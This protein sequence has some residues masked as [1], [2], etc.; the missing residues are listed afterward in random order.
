[1]R[2]AGVEGHLKTHTQGEYSSAHKPQ[3]DSDG[4]ADSGAR[5]LVVGSVIINAVPAHASTTHNAIF[6]LTKIRSA[7][8]RRAVQVSLQQILGA[9]RG[10]A[11]S[12]SRAWL[13]VCLDAWRRT[14][15]V[16]LDPIDGKPII[17]QP[18]I[19]I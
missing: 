2:D 17:V 6:V 16:D 8:C 19:A 14:M 9:W 15:D 18:G 13:L 3:V 12:R 1:M 4:S 7:P 11:L 5:G 10:G